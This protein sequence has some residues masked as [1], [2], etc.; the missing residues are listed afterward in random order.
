MNRS[1]DARKL[2][3]QIVGFNFALRSSSQIWDEHSHQSGMPFWAAWPRSHDVF[4]S[5]IDAPTAAIACPQNNQ[6]VTA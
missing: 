1:P 3:P 4:A 5:Q 6:N 2:Q